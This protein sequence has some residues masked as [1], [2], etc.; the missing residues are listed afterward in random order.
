MDTYDCMFIHVPNLSN[1]YL[2]TGNFA[3]TN[4]I[5][6]GVL[7]LA[8]LAKRSGYRTQV[9]HMGVE[10]LRDNNFSINEYLR[11]CKV[12]VLGISLFWYHQSYD[13][14]ELAREIKKHNPDIF[15]YM[16]GL[17]ASYFSE[18]ILRE[19][20]FVD[21]VNKG[22]GE[23][24]LIGLLKKALNNKEIKLDE[25]NGWVFRDNS[26]IKSTQFCQLDKK[27]FNDLIYADLS[28]VKNY[29]LYVNYF[30]LH[31]MPV[32]VKDVRKLK[33]DKLTKM[34]PL[35]VGRGCGVVCS[36]CGGNRNTWEKCAGKD[37]LVWRDIEKVI[38]DIERAIGYGY[39]KIFIC[40]D[41]TPRNQS[42]YVELFR[43]MR[44]RNIN[45]SLYFEC[46][47]LPTIEFIKEF[48][49]TFKNDRLSHILI[50][51]DTIS[52]E[53]R[54]KNRGHNYSNQELF[55]CLQ[56]L[57]EYKIHFDV[58]LSLGLPG[59]SFIEAIETKA[60]MKRICRDYK[61]AGR[62]MAFL[63]DLVP[64]SPMFEDPEKY[65]IVTQMKSFMDY[66]NVFGKPGHPT[67]AFCKYKIL[68]YF[69]DERDT[70]TIEDFAKRIQHL[71]CMHFCFAG[72]KTAYG[73]DAE[74]GRKICLEDRKKV[75]NELGIDS[76]PRI[77]D[78]NY[79]YSDEL[80]ILENS[81]R[82]C[83]RAKYL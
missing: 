64:G 74:Q 69:G 16:G 12:K 15:V 22:Y 81:N 58:C 68:D 1:F 82:G 34:F 75:Y 23:Q 9:L 29:E 36:Y 78:D 24:S 55:G 45:V 46:W 27:L 8:N 67:Y 71:K 57:D 63:I 17:T 10:R 77:F 11:N 18:E 51:M 39:N 59:S 61:Y 32:I 37:Y 30:G 38:A 62:V 25:L 47:G 50:S 14:I 42:Y 60:L 33:I 41:P 26:Q 65:N 19:F 49:M 3:N 70:G 7:A 21:A 53:L 44:E 76:Q 40:F 54:N 28:V 52:E 35:S 2:P 6:M 5:P 13:A 48:S 43:R 56:N 83:E 66:Y 73:M 79:G 72:G 20:P 80:E 4:L 31:E